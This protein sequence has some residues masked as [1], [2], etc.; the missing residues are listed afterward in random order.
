MTHPHNL[1]A[2]H[3]FRDPDSLKG[4]PQ[5]N[6]DD[7]RKR[8]QREIKQDKK[9]QEAMFAVYPELMGTCTQPGT[10]SPLRLPRP[11]PSLSKSIWASE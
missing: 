7:T 9:F 6:Y 1:G 8:R 2:V 11:E 3:H 5:T 4:I 10:H